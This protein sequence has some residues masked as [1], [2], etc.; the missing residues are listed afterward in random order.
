[1]AKYRVEGIFV[2]KSYQAY[3]DVEAENDNEAYDVALGLFVDKGE[4]AINLDAI[5]DCDIIDADI[6]ELDVEDEDV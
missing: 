1:M 3:V 5:F 2:L 6:Y 4:S